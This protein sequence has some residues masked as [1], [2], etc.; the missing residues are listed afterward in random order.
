MNYNLDQENIP[1][2]QKHEVKRRLRLIEEGK[3]KTRSWEEAKKEI[4]RK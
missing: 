4:F 2:W 3:M 1:N